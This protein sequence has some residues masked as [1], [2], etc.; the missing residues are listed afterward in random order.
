MLP[1][2]RAKRRVACVC[3][4]ARRATNIILVVRYYIVARSWSSANRSLV[5]SGANTNKYSVVYGIVWCD[6]GQVAGVCPA[7]HFHRGSTDETG[8]YYS[9]VF[10][11]RLCSY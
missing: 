2:R 1:T 4:L 9:I 5:V 8:E 10:L 3:S 6:V 11:V 7:P